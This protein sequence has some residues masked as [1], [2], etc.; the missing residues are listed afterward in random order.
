MSHAKTSV[1]N[2]QYFT[3]KIQY[4][5]YIAFSFEYTYMPNCHFVLKTM[6]LYILHTG[7]YSDNS[8]VEK[9]TRT[10]RAKRV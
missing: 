8:A 10:G 7:V 1:S 4:T 3:Y 2:E 6:Y 5:L 9:P